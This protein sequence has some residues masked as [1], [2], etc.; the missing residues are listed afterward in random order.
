MKNKKIFIPVFCLQIVFCLFLDWGGD[1]LA[2]R[3][4]WPAWLDS[5]GTALAAY[6]LLI[7]YFIRATRK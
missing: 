4:N 3:L 5:L 6:L 2:T 7:V 1:L